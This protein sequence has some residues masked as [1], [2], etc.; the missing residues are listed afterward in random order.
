MPQA[1]TVGINFVV[2]LTVHEY[3]LSKIL[4]SSRLKRL[5]CNEEF[6]LP[7]VDVGALVGSSFA[8]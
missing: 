6:W 7:R 3:R 1:G 2:A 8:G 4:A 5:L